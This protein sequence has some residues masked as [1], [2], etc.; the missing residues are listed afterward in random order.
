MEYYP[1]G[2]KFYSGGWADDVWHGHGKLYDQHGEVEYNGRMVNGQP[3]MQFIENQLQEKND[4]KNN[5]DQVVKKKTKG[6]AIKTDAKKIVRKV[7][8]KNKENVMNEGKPKTKKKNTNKSTSKIEP[9][10]E[11]IRRI[12]ID[13]MSTI[14]AEIE[15]ERKL[16]SSRAL[17][18]KN[19]NTSQTKFQNPN[20]SNVL[21]SPESRPN[22]QSEDQATQNS[23]ENQQTLVSNEMAQE[24][25]KIEDTP[26]NNNEIQSP[27][28]EESKQANFGDSDN[29]DFSNAQYSGIINEDSNFQGQ[30][31]GLSPIN[32]R[33][34]DFIEE[35]QESTDNN[36]GNLNDEIIENN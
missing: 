10:K 9:K 8:T 18:A 16:V 15:S 12:P 3:Y 4:E 32:L 6:L 1:N 19:K 2:D 5:R 14:S 11:I 7:T 33:E 30:A 13:T 21:E 27:D 35:M 29:K 22:I 20:I 23:P 26:I 24:N 31:I 25:P 34:Q 28:V 36:I 17:N